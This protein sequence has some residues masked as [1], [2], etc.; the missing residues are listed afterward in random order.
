MKISNKSL[1]VQIFRSNDNRNHQKSMIQKKNKAKD[2]FKC[3]KN[4]AM[5][6]I[7]ESYQMYKNVI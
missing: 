4:R 3:T 1:Y 6:E 2:E 5:F 7:Y